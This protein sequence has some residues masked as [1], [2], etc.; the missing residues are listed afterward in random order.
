EAVIA[1]DVHLAD[2]RAL[3]FLYVDR[4]AYGIVWTFLDVRIND[5]RILA[6][7]VI[8]LAEELLHIIQHGTVE[9]ASASQPDVAQGV[10]E[11]FGLDVLVAL[12]REVFDR[13]SLLHRDDQG[14]AVTAHFDVV[15]HA[16]RVQRADRLLDAERVNRVADVDRQVVEYGAFRN[17]LQSLDAHVAHD[18]LV[19]R[20]RL[21]LRLRACTGGEHQQHGPQ[22]MSVQTARDR[23]L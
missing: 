17:P 22:P 7:I 20:K 9:G 5:D 4:D 16:L 18:E 12:D 6:A 11:I 19:P 15:E 21:R 10:H 3:A 1:D 8:L 14:V 23:Q 2:L 13:R